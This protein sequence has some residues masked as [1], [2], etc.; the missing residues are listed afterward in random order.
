MIRRLLLS[1][2]ILIGITLV[3]FCIIHLAG[4]PV[5]IQTQM[6]AKV[7]AETQVRLKEFYGLDK[8]L[9]VQYW[10][11]IKRLALGDF[12]RSFV[13]MRLVKEKIM[14]RL[15]A[16]LELNILAMLIIFV[17]A[18]PLGVYSASHQH[19]GFDHVFTMVTF[20]GYALPTFWLALLLMLFFGIILDWLPIAGMS[21]LNA[22]F[23]P[24]WH[25][26][27]D[28]LRHLALPLFVSAFGGFAGISRYTRSSM[29]EVLRQDYIR[30]A[31]AKGVSPFKVLGKHALKNALLPVI[32]ILG[33]SI[34][35]LI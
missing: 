24:W 29:L 15:P 10:L 23:M 32:T 19:S 27:L 3:T 35:G 31:K 12:G 28:H 26:C 16:T 4:N 6:N 1:F 5:T 11:W 17:V 18:I 13:D 2:P 8:P 20:V 33:L 30:T 9:S 25:Q 34:P 21:S 22:D 7:S 14:E